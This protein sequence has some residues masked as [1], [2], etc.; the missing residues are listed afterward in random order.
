MFPGSNANKKMRIRVWSIFLTRSRLYIS[1]DSNC[2]LNLIFCLL[3]SGF[4]LLSTVLQSYHDST[5]MRQVIVLPHCNPPAA[6]TWQ[7]H[8]TQ[9]HYQL[10]PGRPAIFPSTSTFQCRALAREL[11]VPSFNDFWSV[12]AGDRTPDLPH[13]S[14]TLYH[15]GA[16][17]TLIIQSSSP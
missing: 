14:P 10:T 3:N 15:C 8:P 17:G 1:Q 2:F 13:R 4:T 11:L 7:E 5:C 12:S 6:G 16:G 9:S